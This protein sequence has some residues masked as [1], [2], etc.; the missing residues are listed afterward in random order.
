MVVEGGREG[1]GYSN[2]E[3]L[4]PFSTSMWSELGNKVGA[5]EMVQ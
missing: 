1:G 2:L 4:A 3:L 5:K